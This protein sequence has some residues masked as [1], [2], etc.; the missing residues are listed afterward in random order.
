MIDDLVNGN[1]LTDIVIEAYLLSID[2]K[3]AMFVYLF[4]NE[5]TNKILLE[6]K[7]PKMSEVILTDFRQLIGVV[8]AENHFSCF[9][10]ESNEYYET[11]TFSYINSLNDELSESI[12]LDMYNNWM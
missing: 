8:Y 9:Y 7:T 5:I 4:T 2:Y 1:W 12:E 3:R 11:A 6:R 10:V